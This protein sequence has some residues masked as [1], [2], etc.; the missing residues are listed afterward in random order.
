MSKLDLHKTNLKSRLKIAEPKRV[1]HSYQQTIYGKIEEIMP[2]YCPVRELE[3]CEGWNP[4][5][6]YSYSGLVEKDCIFT[7]PEGDSE[8]IWVVTDY[9]VENGYVSMFY[10]VPNTL[11]TKL[12]IQLTMVL[13]HKTMALITY[14]KTSLSELGNEALEKFTKAEFNI[15]MDSWAKAMNHYLI[16][17][18][19]LTGLPNF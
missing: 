8:N 17:N 9:D 18:E 19:M 4:K 14:T 11:V 7:T 16:T 6:V 2:L 1:S 13:E 3:W 15:T 12:E 10:I 5:A